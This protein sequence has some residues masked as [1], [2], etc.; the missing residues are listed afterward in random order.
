MRKELRL[1]MTVEKGVEKRY[2]AGSNLTKGENKN[3]SGA[4]IDTIGI[5]GGQPMI[6]IP[7]Y[8]LL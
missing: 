2:K 4:K 5:D 7:I 8:T 6:Y 1:G 3:E